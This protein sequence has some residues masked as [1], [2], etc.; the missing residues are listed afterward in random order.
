MLLSYLLK[1][2]PFTLKYAV[3]LAL[4]IVS[5][6]INSITLVIYFQ[7][8]SLGLICCYFLNFLEWVYSSLI[9]SP[10]FPIDA[11]KAINFFLA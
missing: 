2:L 5:F 7:L 8:Y 11:S 3:H 1:V 4:L 10:S 6:F 9:F